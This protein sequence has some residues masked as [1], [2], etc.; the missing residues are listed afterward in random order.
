MSRRRALAGL[1]LAAALALSG[2]SVQ[3]Y[4]FEIAPERFVE[5]RSRGDW[6]FA[7]PGAAYELAVERRLRSSLEALNDTSRPTAERIGAYQDELRAAGRMLVETLRAQPAQPTALSQLAA[8]RWELD[9]PRTPEAV[10]SHLE[11]IAVASRLAPRVPAVQ[12][13]LG[14][15]LLKMGRRE[16][17]AGYLRRT[18]ELDPGF[19]ARVVALM[20]DHLFS[21][22]QML[23]AL[24]PAAETLVALEP[25][26]VDESRGPAYL[27]LLDR[28]MAHGRL[29][30][31]LITA[32]AS[33][34]LK[35]GEPVRL[36]DRMERLGR[37]PGGRLEAERLRQRSK[38]HLALASPGAALED[39]RQAL[40]FEPDNA[41]LEEHLGQVSLAVGD[42]RMAVA[43]F[44]RALS[45]VA[46]QSGSPAWRARLYAQ[47]GA[48]EERLGAPGRAYDAYRRALALKAD[49]PYARRRLAEMEGA[50]GK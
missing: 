21:S 38:A 5:R 13:R 26:F 29:S 24:P 40:Q 33:V 44:R 11:C 34:C 10:R 31:A 2:L 42:P 23:R 22:E 25:L 9:P 50:A 36:R 30:A 37:L 28:E 3:G 35:L 1:G 49:E 41:S 12:I 43:A 46:R 47:I 27:D 6:L 16:E 39:A 32:Y 19:S 18:V 7:P 45:A 17:A 4:R 15:L 14:E 48:A 20:R 8:V